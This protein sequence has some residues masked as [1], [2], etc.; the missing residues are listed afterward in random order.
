[1]YT[2][3][4]DRSNHTCANLAIQSVAGVASATILRV[5]HIAAAVRRDSS[6]ATGACAVVC[7]THTHHTH[8]DQTKLNKTKPT[9]NTNKHV[10]I[11]NICTLTHLS[12]QSVAGIAGSA[13]L[14]AV[15]LAA[16][17]RRDSSRTIHTGAGMRCMGR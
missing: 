14:S 12:T 7:C 4:N 8:T 17:I 3:S 16:T 5:I 13:V 9:N 10:K 11:A 15:N 2:I 1:M 6:S